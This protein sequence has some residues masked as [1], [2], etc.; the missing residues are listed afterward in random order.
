MNKNLFTAFMIVTTFFLLVNFF[1]QCSGSSKRN[2]IDKEYIQLKH[3]VDSLISLE[4][5][6]E[7]NVIK[8]ATPIQVKNQMQRTMLDFLIY[9]DDLDKGKTSLSVIKDKIESDDEK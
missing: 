6:R 3:T 7:D 4:Q 9:E 1:Q 5:Q 2:K 8:P